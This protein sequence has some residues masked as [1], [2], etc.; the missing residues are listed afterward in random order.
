MASGDTHVFFYGYS[1]NGAPQ[2]VLRLEL[3]YF[4]TSYQMRSAAK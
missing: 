4:T 2:A 1:V 3:R